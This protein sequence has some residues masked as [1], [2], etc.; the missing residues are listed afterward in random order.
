MLLFIAAKAFVLVTAMNGQSYWFFGF[1][2]SWNQGGSNSG[3][4]RPSSNVG[5]GGGHPDPEKRGGTISMKFFWALQFGPQFGLKIRE[6][7]PPPT[8]IRQRVI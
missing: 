7:S 5:G 4:S 6:T 8:W 2:V 1:N 3:G